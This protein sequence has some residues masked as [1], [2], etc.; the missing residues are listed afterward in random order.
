M[1]NKPLLSFVLLCLASLLI[2]LA[3]APIDIW[4]AH[5]AYFNQWTLL[6]GFFNQNLYEHGIFGL[7]DIVVTIGVVCVLIYG[8]SFTPAGIR[9]QPFRAAA[10]YVLNAGVTAAVSIVHALKWMI[11]RTRPHDVYHVHDPV[12]EPELELY[13]HW[14]EPG[15]FPLEVGFNRGAFPG[16]HVA[17]MSVLLALVYFIPERHARWRPAYVAVVIGAAL[18]MA[19]YRM[20]DITHWATDNIGGLLVSLI[21]VYGLYTFIHFPSQHTRRLHP[22]TASVDHRRPGWELLLM[23]A[24][25]LGSFAIAAVFVGLRIAFLEENVLRGLGISAGAL[26][27]AGLIGLW[28]RWILFPRRS[29]LLA[30]KPA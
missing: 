9:L 29:S 13:T 26:F 18:I 23:A 30:S 24:T 8:L 22:W 15:K 21:V 10:G 2:L 19:W 16:G 14:F 7:A 12:K 4:L 25:L 28:I 27:G 6:K 3:L 11:A 1:R 20:M 17:T 5:R